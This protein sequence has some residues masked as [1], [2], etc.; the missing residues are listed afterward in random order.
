MDIHRIIS[1]I[2]PSSSYSPASPAVEAWAPANIALIK[3]WGKRDH[4]LNLPN[5]PSLS[6][7]LGHYGTI[8]RITTAP[9]QG[10]H[11]VY[12]QNRQLP[13]SHPLAQ[14]VLE[15]LTLLQVPPA[16]GLA[17]HTWNN[18]PT[19]AGLAS[20]ASGIAA[21]VL[22][23][24]HFF[25]WHLPPD[26]LSVLCRMGS[27]SACRSLYRGFVLWH[28]GEQ[29]DGLDSFAE[30]IPISW[31]ELRIGILL[32]HSEEKKMSS[33]EGMNHTVETSPLYPAWPSFAT[34]ACKALAEQLPQRELSTIGPLIEQNAL[35]MHA[36]MIAA[37]PALIYWQPQTL[38]AIQR[39]RQLREQTGRPVFFTIDAGPNV[40]VLFLEEEEDFILTHFPDMSIINPFAGDE[41]VRSP[42]ARTIACEDVRKPPPEEWL[43][44]HRRI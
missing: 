13:A 27:G 40:K 12:F 5:N 30:P 14:R 37:D 28:R 33:R 20:S 41:E 36:T 1:R 31:P 42:H 38:S 34:Q 8:T 11:T 18:I 39:I 3:Y 26:K 9:G 29:A 15:L 25:A 44:P 22:A 43:N 32:L 2:L 10:P 21:L 7:S 16:P 24:N 35:T 23:L 17:I 6:I 4:A 19:A